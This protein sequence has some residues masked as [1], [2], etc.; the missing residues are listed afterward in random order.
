[1]PSRASTANGKLT[2]ALDSG[3]PTL[4]AWS[5]EQWHEPGT[6]VDA[7]MPSGAAATLASLMAQELVLTLEQ[8]AEQVKSIVK[9]GKPEMASKGPCVPRPLTPRPPT[10]MPS[11]ALHTSVRELVC[12]SL[13]VSL[14]HLHCQSGEAAQEAWPDSESTTTSPMSSARS[15]G[16]ECAQASL[17]S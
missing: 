8:P 1:M 5:A 6:E 9:P 17:S 14:H 7:V 15:L 12:R 4:S 13:S 3:I 16:S 2:E 10:S 11:H